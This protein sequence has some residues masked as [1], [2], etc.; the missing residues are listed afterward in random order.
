MNAL[1]IGR[2]I[3]GVGG[4]GIYLGAINIISVFTTV[5]ERPTQLSFFGVSWGLGTV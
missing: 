2:A 1:I 5:Q 4:S 3:C